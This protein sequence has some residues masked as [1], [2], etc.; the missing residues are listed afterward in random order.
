MICQA[1]TPEMQMQFC[2]C[3]PCR[4]GGMS[5]RMHIEWN[6]C[7]EVETSELSEAVQAAC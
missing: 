7:S 6:T 2:M 1:D 3:Q 5:L 4:Q